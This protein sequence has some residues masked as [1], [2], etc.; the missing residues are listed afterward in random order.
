MCTCSHK[1]VRCSGHTWSLLSTGRTEGWSFPYA[2]P[3]GR[4]SRAF[5][6]TGCQACPGLWHGCAVSPLPGWPPVW[7]ASGCHGHRTVLSP[8]AWASDKPGLFDVSRRRVTLTFSLDAVASV[9]LS[10]CHWSPA[11][12][13]QTWH[14]GA[15]VPAYPPGKQ[16]EPLAETRAPSRQSKGHVLKLQQDSLK[17]DSRRNL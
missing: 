9:V 6:R 14:Q 10:V 2:L 13:T 3:P 11:T 1:Q 7:A 8:R 15:S 12:A 5:R 4:I 17:A 16:R